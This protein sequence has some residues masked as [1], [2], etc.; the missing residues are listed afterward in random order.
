[1][2][3]FRYLKVGLSVV[4]TFV[5]A[6]MLLA[7]VYPIPIMVTLLIVGGIIL[8]SIFA[9]IIWPTEEKTKRPD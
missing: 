4:L 2:N 6:K 1:M 9:S 8:F 3:L 7:Q 5:G